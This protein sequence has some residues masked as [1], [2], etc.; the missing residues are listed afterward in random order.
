MTKLKQLLNQLK[1]NKA[2]ILLKFILSIPLFFIVN[3]VVM[4]VLAITEVWRVAED[5][6]CEC[7]HLAIDLWKEFV[8]EYNKND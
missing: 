5:Y 4:I 7:F 3:L 8:E 1:N 2:I 6:T